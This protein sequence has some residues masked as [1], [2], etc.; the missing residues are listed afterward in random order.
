M[1][2]FVPFYGLYYVISRFDEVRQLLLL[3]F[4]GVLLVVGGLLLNMQL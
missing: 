1:Y 3:S 4:A 2:L